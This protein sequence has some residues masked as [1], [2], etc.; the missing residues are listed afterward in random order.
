MKKFLSLFLV[1]IIMISLSLEVRALSD[2]SYTWKGAPVSLK[3]LSQKLQ[4]EFVE[5]DGSYKPM[6]AYHAGQLWEKGLFLGSDGSFDLDRPL[7]RAQGI[8]MIVRILGKEKEALSNQNEIPFRDVANWA[9]PYVAYAVEHKIAKGYSD[10]VFGSDDA[11]SAV[12]YLTLVLRSMGYQDNVDFIWNE[13]YNK[14]LEIG[15][16]GDSCKMQYQDSNLFLRDHAAVISYQALFG[17]R[18]KS[19]ENLSEG[20]VMGEKP[21]GEMPTAVRSVSLSPSKDASLG[22][23]LTQDLSGNNTADKPAPKDPSLSYYQVFSSIVPDYQSIDSNAEGEFLREGEDYYYYY[24]KKF[25]KSK[26]AEYE[27]LLLTQGFTNM[28]TVRDTLMSFSYQHYYKDGINVAVGKTRS[29]REYHVRIVN[30]PLGPV[31]TA[32]DLRRL[33][34]KVN[35][36]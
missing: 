21:S 11:M 3:E 23:G 26:L 1:I 7:T 15:L 5:E 28:G 12:Q 18:T 14:A 25:D 27:A 33:T 8:V 29:G 36:L 24:Y 32:D 9:K 34:S 2:Q 16:I 6:Y 22:S 30:M 10:T 19:G 35:E 17:A 4:M 20:I 13:S 31:I